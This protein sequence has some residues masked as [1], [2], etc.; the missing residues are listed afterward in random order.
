MSLM[1]CLEKANLPKN[2]TVLDNF[3]RAHKIINNPS[4]NVIICSLSGGSDSDIMLDII[5]KVDEQNKVH[6]VWFDTGLEYR[7]TKDHLNY[8]EQKYNIKIERERAIKPIPLSCK[9]YGQPFIS[10]EVSSKIEGLQRHNFKFE[11]KPY[12][13]LLNEYPK[14][15]CYIDWWCGIKVKDNDNR[16]TIYQNKYL[17]E[18]LIKYPPTFK[19]SSKCCNYAKKNVSKEMIKKYKADLLIIGVRKAEGGVRATAYKNCFSENIHGCAQYRPLFFYLDSDKLDYEKSCNIVHSDCYK[20]WGFKRTGCVG[21]PYNIK[22]QEDLLKVKKYEPKLY[23]AVNNVF[24]DSYEYTK[25]YRQFVQDM[26]LKEK[27]IKKLF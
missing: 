10:K 23:K 17:K 15:K 18:F 20:V 5:S 14:A 22:I 7:A 9:E 21:C 12:N 16:F 19:I 2:Q 24:K 27:G 4:Y 3:I 8:L 26:K 1:E 13:I 25:Q 11:D 6:Y